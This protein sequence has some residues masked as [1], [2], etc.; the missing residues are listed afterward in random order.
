MVYVACYCNYWLA[1]GIRGCVCHG[2]TSKIRLKK[3]WKNKK[4]KKTR[5]LNFEALKESCATIGELAVVV[6]QHQT[7]SISDEDGI[8]L[9]VTTE[10]REILSSL[11]S[12]YDSNKISA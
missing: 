5:G 11:S 4:C 12:C 8:F 10:E 7:F 3:V 9:Q 6:S 1:D 2:Q